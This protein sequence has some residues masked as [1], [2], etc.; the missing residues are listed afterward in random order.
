MY[1]VLKLENEINL[2]GVKLNKLKVKALNATTLLEAK[3][4]EPS[5]PDFEKTLILGVFTELCDEDFDHIHARDYL[6]MSHVVEDMLTV[7]EK[8]DFLP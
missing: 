3:Q 2:N 8:P 7:E 1:D 5:S 6:R 4:F